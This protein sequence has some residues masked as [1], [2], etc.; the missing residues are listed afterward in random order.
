[1]VMIFMVIDILN[2]DVD[3]RACT[4]FNWLRQGAYIKERVKLHLYSPSVNLWQVI[5]WNSTLHGRR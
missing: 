5:R 2:L 1:M 3:E 4:R